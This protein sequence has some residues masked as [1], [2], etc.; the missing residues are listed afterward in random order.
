VLTEHEF[1]VPVDHGQ[2][3]GRKLT[4]FA[5]EVAAPARERDDPQWLV[6]F[7]GGPGFE[8]ARPLKPTNPTWLERALEDYRVLLLDQ[9]GTGR[10]K[11]G[12]DCAV[13]DDLTFE[14]AAEEAEAAVNACLAT[15][16][17]DPKLYTTSVAVRDLDELRATLAVE[18][19]NVYGVSYGTR[20]AQH[21]ARRF[22][23]RVRT[24]ILDGVVP[25]ELALGP[26]VAIQAQRALDRIFARCAESVDCATRFAD[27]PSRFDELL[28]KLAAE[29][30]RE[31][32]A[33]AAADARFGTAE[34]QAF[35]RFMSYAAQTAAL[36]PLLLAQAHDGNHGPLLTQARTI[37]RGL[38]EALAFA[39]S[40]SVLCTEDVQFMPADPPAEIGGTY[41]GTT[42]VDGLRSICANWP[43]GTID[44]DF[45][46]PLATDR[47][48]LLLS[49]SADPITPPAYAE[50]AIAGGIT[51]NRH[52]VGRDQGHGLALVGCVP[53]LLR[54][55][56]EEPDPH[57]LD[58][59]CLEIEPAPPFFL[60]PLGPGP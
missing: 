53:R 60:T 54:D 1:E 9:R 10:S 8:A 17:H 31:P 4:V 2:P 45:K 27:S 14:T 40:N 20:V 28:A 55:F 47:P 24:L 52:L 35:T 11:A 58:A 29:P 36:L 23:E 32:A 56:L 37:L 3:D 15:L 26:D 48:T 13:R 50:L 21:Y 7:Q 12:F 57:A 25:A 18:S 51:N 16:E 33:G 44:P 22:P 6:F 49:G 30:L 41:L 42:I 43:V 34:L 39:M 19:W 5:R 38:P 46:A 59:S